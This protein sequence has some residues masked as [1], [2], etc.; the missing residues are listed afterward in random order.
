MA[1]I[2]V[3]YRGMSNEFLKTK[4]FVLDK[5]SLGEMPMISFYT[6]HKHV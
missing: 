6:W 5:G 1:L 3:V 2:K 4:S